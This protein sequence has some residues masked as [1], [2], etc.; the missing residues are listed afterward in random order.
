MGYR[1]KGRELALQA[2]YQL[3]VT[4]EQSPATIQ[5]FLRHFEAAEQATAFAQSLL[6]G[7]LERR[8]EI[9]RLIGEASQHWR[10]ERLSKIDL[11]VLRMATYELM[12]TPEVPV[13]VVLDEAIE[14]ARRFGSGESA[15]FVNG[16]L[17]AIAERLGA[18]QRPENA[19]RDGRTVPTRDD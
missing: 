7:V 5:A 9:D 13:N 15:V 12:A 11:N 14:I 10:V 4:G 3:E 17:D 19:E 1:R 6:L 8:E 18:K 2:L 16:V